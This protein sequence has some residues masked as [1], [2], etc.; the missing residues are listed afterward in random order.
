MDSNLMKA[1][2][3]A[4]S[5]TS[6]LV[7]AFVGKTH[8]EILG[9]G[10]GDVREEYLKL[11]E[12]VGGPKAWAKL[13]LGTDGLLRLR[14]KLVKKV[15]A[16]LKEERQLLRGPMP[17]P[18]EKDVRVL[19]NK[20]IELLVLGREPQENDSATL[21]DPLTVEVHRKELTRNRHGQIYQD[22]EGDGPRGQ[23][24]SF[25][26][27][28][29][30]Y[31]GRFQHTRDDK[32]SGWRDNIHVGPVLRNEDGS[33]FF[34]GPSV[35]NM[36]GGFLTEDTV[37]YKELK[38]RL[39]EEPERLFW[40]KQG[41]SSKKWACGMFIHKDEQDRS[42]Y[43]WCWLS[44]ESSEK[45]DKRLEVKAKAP[46]SGRLISPTGEWWVDFT[47]WETSSFKDEMGIPMKP[48]TSYAVY[49]RDP[50][51][52]ESRLVKTS[53]KVEGMKRSFITTEKFRELMDQRLSEGW[54]LTHPILPRQKKE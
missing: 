41:V 24:L 42:I 23:G 2:K 45:L 39:R 6:A 17:K 27:Y 49:H 51:T 30:L 32:V 28:K 11:V 9:V 1:V 47:A 33:P 14:Q 31:I 22:L 4:V 21:F 48:S 3:A 36:R 25:S 52:G 12:Q 46:L 26:V 37:H 29:N 13:M 40:I 19:V 53:Y 35:W 8:E 18:K 15:K 5:K 10:F 44:K 38:R 50:K 34:S 54:V 16:G 20:E 43:Y 7:E